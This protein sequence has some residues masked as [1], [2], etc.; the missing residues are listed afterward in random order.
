MLADG[1]F[2]YRA[3]TS[4][5]QMI[6]DLVKLNEH[7]CIIMD[8]ANCTN[9]PVIFATTNVTETLSEQVLGAVG[10]GAKGA[11]SDYEY[12]LLTL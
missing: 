1:V 10:E 7:G 6:A 12:L 4:M 3:L 2:V 5:S 9:V 11:L 8:C